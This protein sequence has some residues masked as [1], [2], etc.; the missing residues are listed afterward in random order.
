[1]Q[2]NQLSYDERAHSNVRWWPKADPTLLQSIILEAPRN[3]RDCRSCAHGGRCKAKYCRPLA[4]RF[5]PPSSKAL[6]KPGFA[7]PLLAYEIGFEE[8]I[9]SL[10]KTLKALTR[11][12][13]VQR[14]EVQQLESCGQRIVP[15][16][17]DELSA[18][19]QKLIP[20]HAWAAFDPDDTVKRRVCDYIAGMTDPYAERIYH[21]LFTPRMGS[22]RDEL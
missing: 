14:A 1:M 8:P 13:V 16:L 3:R 7:H 15:S 21:R 6:P 9:A 10:L 20:A 12:L 18:K 5:R 19:P 4:H 22:S 2:L 11:Q 17:F